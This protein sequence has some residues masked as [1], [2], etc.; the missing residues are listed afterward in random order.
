[1]ESNNKDKANVESTKTISENPVEEK[2]EHHDDD[3]HNHDAIN[4]EPEAEESVWK[5][6]WQLSLTSG[7][8]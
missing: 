1:M 2:H 7:T 4:N 3:G 8:G 5:S 6:H